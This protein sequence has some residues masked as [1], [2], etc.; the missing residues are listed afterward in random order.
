MRSVTLPVEIHCIHGDLWPP[1]YA[2]QGIP[3]SVARLKMPHDAIS[4][5]ETWERECGKTKM[6]ERCFTCKHV[7]IPVMDDFQTSPAKRKARR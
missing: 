3:L 1:G 2:F 4:R 7:R 5:A 6:D